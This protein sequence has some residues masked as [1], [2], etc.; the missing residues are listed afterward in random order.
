MIDKHADIDTG[1]SAS[2]AEFISPPNTIKAKVGSGG[3]P[4][5]VLNQAQQ[6]L[7]NHS[8]DF[9]PVS[10]LYLK[11]LL[12][13]IQELKS[14]ESMGNV[15]H[16]FGRLM[17]PVTQLKSNGAMF[18]YPIITTMATKLIHFI[19]RIDEIDNHVIEIVEAFHNAMYA[20]VQSQ[21]K[22]ADGEAAGL[23]FTGALDKACQRYFSS[24]S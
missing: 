20:V 16:A 5:T 4:E 13:V 6:M 18:R 17:Y 3:L 10:D 11:T 19:E 9:K 15:E 21:M 7:E 8:V 2:S 14:A 23:K 22:G 24:V 1:Y 12:G